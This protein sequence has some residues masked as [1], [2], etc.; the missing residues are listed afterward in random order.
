MLIVKNE[1]LFYFF[2]GYKCVNDVKKYVIYK[3]FKKI[4]WFKNRLV[5]CM[6]EL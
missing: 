2:V 5:L 3:I 1:G 6:D 4:R